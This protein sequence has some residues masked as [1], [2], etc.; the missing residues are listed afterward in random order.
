[1]E[2]MSALIER[3]ADKVPSRGV[4]LAY[5]EKI[6]LD[7]EELVPV[8]LVTYGFGGGGDQDDNGG[9]GGGG[10]AIPVGAYVRRGETLTFQPNLVA[11][12][13]VA[14]PLVVSAGWA[15][16]KIARALR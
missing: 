1:M 7:G 2:T 9:G 8:A 6:E 13:A 14:I 4:T 3:L 5:G 12:M 15:L 16:S 11:L 10:A